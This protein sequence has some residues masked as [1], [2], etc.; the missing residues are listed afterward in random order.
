MPAAKT[1]HVCKMTP[2][3]VVQLR[4]LLV[5]AGWCFDELAHGHWRASKDKTTVAAYLSGKVVVQGRGTADVVQFVIEP[6]ILKEARFGYEDELA[7]V[8]NPD[9]FQPHAGVDESG[10][11]D[12]FGPMV[13]A[14][15]YTDENSARKL[16]DA[17]VMDSKRI[18]SDV[19]IAKLAETIKSVVQGRFSI[20]PIGPEAYNRMHETMRNVNRILAWGHARAI[21]NILEKVGDCPRALSDKFANEREIKR[22]LMEKGRNIKLEQRTKAESDI[23]V[24][25]ASILARAE[26]VRRLEALGHEAGMTLPKGAGTPVLMAGRRLAFEKGPAVFAKFA[27]LH[28]RTTQKVIGNS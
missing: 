27:K 14:A 2:E 25:A 16:L 26:F 5:P 28:F 21:E 18:K 13:V 3:Q 7:V 17:G 4:N 1:M 15:A 10:K 11:G 24:A 9:M 20:V 12:Y 23:A 22:V 8:E 19:K 6:E